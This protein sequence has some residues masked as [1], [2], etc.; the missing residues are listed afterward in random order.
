MLIMAVGGLGIFL[1]GMKFMSEGMQSV[2]GDKLRVLINKVTDNR[3]MATG[4]GAAITALIQSSSVTTVM[5]VGMVNA[6][7]MTLR[8]GI[9][10]IMGAN[11]GT[12]ITAWIISLNVADYGLP[13]LGIAAFVYL[14]SKK[15]KVRTVAMLILGLGMVFYGLEIMKSGFYPLRS[16]KEFIALLAKFSP[17]NYIGLLKCVFIGAFVTAVIQSSS[18][19]IAITLTLAQSGII[20]YNTAI[21]LVLGENIGTTITAFLAS[22]GTTT[23]AKRTAYAHVIIN[24]L[25]AIIM[26]LVFYR[27]LAILK[28][29]LPET[30]PMA[31][32]IA[33]A[34][35]GFNLF[36]VSIF[37]WMIDPLAKLLTTL[38][39]EKKKK[40][41]LTLTFMNVPLLDA[42][43][44]GV[45]QSSA[46][47]LKL[48]DSVESMLGWLG[49]T[50]KKN[51][52]ELDKK[53]VGAEK[54]IDL[55]Q[56]E[57]VEYINELM[58]HNLNIESMNI[59]RKQLRMA[60]EYES[61][62][63]YVIVILKLRDRMEKNSIEFSKED[64][65]FILDLHEMLTDYFVIV[66]TSCRQNDQNILTL[67]LIHI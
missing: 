12:T 54:E 23:T 47:I 30:V 49:A 4:I 14:F 25:G 2:V 6:G 40:E 10:V 35:T 9:G 37:I 61:I 50:L 55:M 11:I 8:Q 62:S 52:D 46:G 65:E 3:F 38:V 66:S 48:I 13:T 43:A 1:L 21:A 67:S 56:K 45:E 57:I 63:D 51:N 28:F 29:I 15:T 59:V 42:P 41:P 34:H 44:L 64:K 60:D 18:A 16:D 20:D 32:R 39:K 58:T 33:F 17:T 53:L 27:Y 24:V 7:I 36:I 26:S 22:L 5:T 19:T 31:G